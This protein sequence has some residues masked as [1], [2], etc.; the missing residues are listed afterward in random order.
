M[1]WFTCLSTQERKFPKGEDKIKKCPTCIP[2]ACLHFVSL[3]ILTLSNGFACMG[4][5]I[6]RGS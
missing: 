3:K 1:R 2:I 6:Q 5:M 4:D